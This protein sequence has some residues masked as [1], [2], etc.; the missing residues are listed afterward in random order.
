MNC[1]VLFKK[2]ANASI[3]VSTGTY[4]A[5]LIWGG[6][7]GQ[8]LFQATSLFYKEREKFCLVIE[9]SYQKI[10]SMNDVYGP[11]L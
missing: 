5:P 10:R 6:T 4:L 9:M 2:S 1:Y 11:H 3:L 8:S 7:E